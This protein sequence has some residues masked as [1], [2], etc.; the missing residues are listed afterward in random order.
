[1]EKNSSR[2]NRTFFGK[3]NFAQ[4]SGNA[5][6]YS[7]ERFAHIRGGVACVFHIDLVDLRK[8]IFSTKNHDYFG[9]RK[10]LK[11]YKKIW[12]LTLLEM[13]LSARQLYPTNL[14]CQAE[15]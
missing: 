4:I 12:A 6:E 7:K 9:K 2:K 14:L 3:K 11:V 1:M 15:H 13:Q 10:S 8:F 5:L